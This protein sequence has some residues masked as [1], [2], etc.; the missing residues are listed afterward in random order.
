M[1]EIDWATEGDIPAIVELGRSLRDESPRYAPCNYSEDKIAKVLAHLVK[2]PTT[3]CALVARKNGK[4][5]GFFLG[6]VS[7]HWFGTSK[8]AGDLSVFVAPE[9]RGSSLFI[10]MLRRF[11]DWAWSTDIE[12]IVL[13]VSTGIDPAVTVAMY[14]RLGYTH[15]GA[16][17]VKRRSDVR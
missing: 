13:A 7:E 17:C 15:Y 12:E 8:F 6:F 2:N 1:A 11:E 3:G 10:K 14:E 16:S 4:M 9:H 5:V